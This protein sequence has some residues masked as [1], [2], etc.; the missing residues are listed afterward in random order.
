MALAYLYL[1]DKSEA[2]SSLEAAY[3][4]RNPAIIY[5]KCDPFWN[6]LRS[7]ARFQ[8]LERKLGM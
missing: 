2:L 3:Q 6:T 8:D 5:I 7:E 4:Q 1:G